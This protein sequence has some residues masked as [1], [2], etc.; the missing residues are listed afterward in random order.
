LARQLGTNEFRPVLL[1]RQDIA[2]RLHFLSELPS[3][4]R[5]VL[6]LDESQKKLL[7]V[8][9]SEPTSIISFR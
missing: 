5:L 4:D 3:R 1:G 2:A 7:Y 8:D 6:I 9:A